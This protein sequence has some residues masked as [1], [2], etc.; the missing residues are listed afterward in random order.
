MET[1]LN[2]S[3]I[4]FDGECNLCN[5]VVG[6]LM[7]FAPE[8]LFH[9]TPFQS[10]QGQEYLKKYGYPTE[11]LDTV[12]LIDEN[13]SH[14]HSDGFLRIVSKIPKW[15]RVAALLAFVPRML[16]DGIYKLASRNRVKWFGQSQSCTINFR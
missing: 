13:G 14:T 11:Q 4:I 2:K 6:W 16:R 5:G 8:D 7:Q 1:S 10:P 9:F 15:K 3:I 12:I